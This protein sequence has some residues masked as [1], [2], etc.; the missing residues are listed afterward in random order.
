MPGYLR[1]EVAQ[2]ALEHIDARPWRGLEGPHW[3]RAKADVFAR[4]HATIGAP[5]QMVRAARMGGIVERHPLLGDLDLVE[6]VLRLPPEHGFDPERSRPDLRRALEGL[7]PDDVRLRREKVTF[8]AV[9]GYSL[10]DDLPVIAPL[11]RDPGARIH[12]YVHAHAIAALV[13]EL[14]VTWG[15]LS[16]WGGRIWRL[17]VMESFLRVQED[18]G[19]ARDLLDSGRLASP[20]LEFTEN[21][22][23]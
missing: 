17:A 22:P 11:I 5:D 8:D 4:R 21:R 12:E 2:V 9:R 1:P 20:R 18:E 7:L 14:P 13:G 16:I 3:W 15:L 23:N 6:L 19:F 10:V